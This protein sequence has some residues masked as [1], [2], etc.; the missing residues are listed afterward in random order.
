[1]NQLTAS[2]VTILVITLFISPRKFFIVPFLIVM[3]FLPSD[4]R[5]TLVGLD[6][7]AS[8]ILVVAGALRLWLQGEVRIIKWNRFDKLL[9]SWAFVGAVVYIIQWGDTQSFIYKCGTLFDIIGMYFLFRQAIRGWPDILFVFKVLA[10][11]SFVLL[12]FVAYEWVTGRNPFDI[13]G[14]ATTYVRSGHYRCNASFGTPIL[15]GLFWVGILPFFVALALTERRKYIYWA[16]AAASVFIVFATASSTPIVTLML[17]ILLLPMFHYRKYGKQA[18]MALCGSVIAL[19]I[20]MTPPVWHLM[21]RVDV[22]VGST[23]WYRY[24]LI[25][26]A[27]KHFAQWALLGTRSTE[28]WVIPSYRAFTDICNQYILEG[29]RGGLVTMI[30]F[31]AVV[32]MAVRTTWRCSLKSVSR[33]QQWLAWSICVSILGHCIAFWG[34]AYFGHIMIF[35]YFTFAMVGTN[36]GIDSLMLNSI[37]AKNA[38]HFNCEISNI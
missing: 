3:C 10:V 36:Y 1:M 31:I 34:V 8:R 37:K 23:G 4:Q 26:Q 6:F 38:T 33:Q 22:V 35:V 21:A 18:V 17:V 16:A 20:I 11:C 7:S 25:D 15:F 5:I 24:H 32:G 14:K 9:L 29:V 19:H 30:L 27:I 28:N 12:P 13:L 2:I